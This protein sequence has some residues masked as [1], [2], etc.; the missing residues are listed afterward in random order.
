MRAIRITLAGVSL[1]LTGGCATIDR[2]AHAD[3]LAKPARMSRMQMNTDP[4]VLTSFVRISDH[5]QPV[6]IYIEGDGLAWLSRTEVSRDPTP[7]NALGLALA[8]VDPAANVVYLARPCQFTEQAR[9][10]V[11][12]LT[13]WTAKRFSPE[14]I[15]AMN[16]AVDQVAA[17][18]PGQKLNLVGYSGGGAVAVLVAA[19][20]QDVASIRTVAGNLDHAEVNRLAKVSQLSGSLNAIDVAGQVAKI[21]Q[22]HYSG[23][24]DPIVPP[25]IAQRFTQASASACVRWMTMPGADHEN[26][27]TG[28]WREALDVVPNCD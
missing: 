26:G 22:I 21:P 17:Q 18:V 10:S 16:Q 5:S 4:F 20:R 13:Y 25:A 2:D 27:W 14:V 12:N 19:R 3:L 24:D 8:A 23:T 28:L 9:S 7:K 1:C 15:A 6:T 11:C